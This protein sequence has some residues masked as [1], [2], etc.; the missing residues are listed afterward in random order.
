MDLFDDARGYFQVCPIFVCSPWSCWLAAAFKIC[1]L[2]LLVPCTVVCIWA[3]KAIMEADEEWSVHKK[4]IDTTGRGVHRA[5]P[6]NFPYFSV[7]FGDEGGYAHVIED[8]AQ[9]PKDFGKVPFS[10]G[11]VLV[12]LS[13]LGRQILML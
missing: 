5:V 3:Q 9:F 2:T 12:N 8:E 11:I 13:S 1:S 7:D 4:L 6:P 10:P